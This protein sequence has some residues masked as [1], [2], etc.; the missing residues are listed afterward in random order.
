[1]ERARLFA[2]HRRCDGHDQGVEEGRVMQR[3]AYKA[4]TV[5][6]ASDLQGVLD[7][8]AAAGWRLV[9]TFQMGGYTMRLIFERP[10]E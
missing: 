9:Q 7:E 1:V 3:W 6:K 8:H 2:G 10:A 5:D 4:V